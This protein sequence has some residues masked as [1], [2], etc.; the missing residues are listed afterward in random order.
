MDMPS[1]R[2]IARIHRQI[3][4]EA[5]KVAKARDNITALRNELE[6]YDEAWTDAAESLAYA[7]N[8]ISE[9]L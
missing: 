4:A 8:R 7:A 1:K 3:S 5:A 2:T 9:L 6:A